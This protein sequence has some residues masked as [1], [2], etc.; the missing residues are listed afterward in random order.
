[1]EQ[2]GE[3]VGGV[4]DD[5]VGKAFE[6]GT[7]FNLPDDRRQFFIPNECPNGP[8]FPVVITVGDRYPPLMST[9]EK[10][11]ELSGS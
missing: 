11:D 4:G 1:M 7:A 3:P 6:I 5:D 2:V 8:Y 10:T 9:P